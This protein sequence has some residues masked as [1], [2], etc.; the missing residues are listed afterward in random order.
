MIARPDFTFDEATHTYRVDGVELPSVSTILRPIVSFD[1]IP[2]DVLAAA[3]ARGVAVH[4]ACELDDLGDLIEESV[5]ESIAG[6]LEAWRRFRRELRAKVFDTEQR[7]YHSVLR[8]AGTRDVIVQIDGKLWLIDRKT[9]AAY[10]W[11]A[12]QLAGYQLLAED[13]GEAVDK[14]GTVLLSSD[15][16]YKLIP[17]G[18]ASDRRVFTSLVTLHTWRSQNV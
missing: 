2:P 17:Y 6:Y 7:R 13:N 11:H 4:K 15:G 18:G 5:D 14:V 3:S 8:Y 10:P 16:G 1:G 12:I 9:S